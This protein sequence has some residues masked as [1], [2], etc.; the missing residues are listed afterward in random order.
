MKYQLTPFGKGADNLRTIELNTNSP[1]T[2]ILGRNTATGLDRLC[3]NVQHVSRNH[4]LITVKEGKIFMH[5]VARQDNLV[6]YNDAVCER[7]EKE[8]KPNDKISLLGSINHFNYKLVLIDASDE[9][10]DQPPPSKKA[11]IDCDKS[12]F[13]AADASVT[14]ADTKVLIVADITGEK[15]LLEPV[16]VCSMTAPLPVDP[17]VGI[18]KQLLQQYECMICCEPTACTY[19]LSPCG[20]VF[21]FTCIEEW[22]RKQS[23]CPHCSQKFD[24]KAAIPSK[25]ADNAIRTILQNNKSMLSEWESRVNCGLDKVKEVIGNKTVHDAPVKNYRFMNPPFPPT[26]LV[27]D[28]APTLGGAS[29]RSTNTRT[30]TRRNHQNNNVAN[31][32]NVA[33][34]SSSNQ[35]AQL[36][37]NTNAPVVDLT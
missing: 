34:S 33:L 9:P 30:Q 17:M 28:S 22:S 35:A 5:P 14:T 36:H 13:S 24:I 18:L 20:D 6:Y 27:L 26:T 25:S 29:N 31:T 8:M 11:R 7:G 21:C 23:V 19:S 32:N 12:V 15:S 10:E 3:D 2:Y 4:I 37:L 1:T 16:P